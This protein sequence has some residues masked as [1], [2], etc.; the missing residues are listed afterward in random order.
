MPLDIQNLIDIFS[1]KREYLTCYT[2]LNNN[3]VN[4]MLS[5]SSLDLYDDA[6]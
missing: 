5:G 4:N 2:K 3:F 1:V 6:A